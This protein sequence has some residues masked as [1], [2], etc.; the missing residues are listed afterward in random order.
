LEQVP[1]L[2]DIFCLPKRTDLQRMEQWLLDTASYGI[3]ISK[4]EE[5]EKSSNTYP[6]IN[7]KHSFYDTIEHITPAF[8]PV[9][10][11]PAPPWC[12][13]IFVPKYPQLTIYFVIRH[14]S[15]YFLHN[16]N[17]KKESYP[18]D[19]AV[20]QRE[21]PSRGLKDCFSS[22]QNQ[23]QENINWNLPKQNIG[24]TTSH[25]GIPLARK[26]FRELLPLINGKHN[27]SEYNQYLKWITYVHIY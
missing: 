15:V 18:K 19:W 6:W 2:S 17:I 27:A 9:A 3:A 11:V 21:I 10:V 20:N 12:T 13:C 16:L 23:P 24:E 7:E 25:E 4:K 14:V 8:S 1:V 22:F 26:H 5:W